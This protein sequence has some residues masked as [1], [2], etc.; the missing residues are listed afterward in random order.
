MPCLIPLAFA[1]LASLAL[2]RAGLINK[3][4]QVSANRVWTG[5]DARVVGIIALIIAIL[6]LSAF[7]YMIWYQYFRG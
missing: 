1:L 7:L 3:Q 4:V 6:I 2:V 5:D